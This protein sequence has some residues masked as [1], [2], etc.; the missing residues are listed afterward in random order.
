MFVWSYTENVEYEKL[1]G[2]YNNGRQTFEIT[3]ASSLISLLVII[4]S[5]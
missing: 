3:A 1:P 2:N 5:I 4:V